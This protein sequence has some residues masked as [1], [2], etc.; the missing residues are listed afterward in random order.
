VGRETGAEVAA[1]ELRRS[2]SAGLLAGAD[3]GAAWKSAKSSSPA[4]V[5][6][7]NGAKAGKAFSVANTALVAGSSSSNPPIKSISLAGSGAFATAAGV[8]DERCGVVAVAP[9]DWETE[10]DLRGDS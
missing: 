9:V 4:S 8:V 5:V 2:M 6:T 7:L 1:E 3:G 10:F